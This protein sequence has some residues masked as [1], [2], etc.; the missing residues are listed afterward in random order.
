MDRVR[1]RT[2]GGGDLL[3]LNRAVALGRARGP[4]DGLAALEELGE[5]PALASCHYLFAARADALHRLGRGVDARAE[6]ERAARLATN[7][8]ERIYLGRRARGET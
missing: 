4:A 7:G 3:R 2:R 6:W 5:S 1:G 8:A